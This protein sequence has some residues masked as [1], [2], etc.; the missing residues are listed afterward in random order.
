MC[1]AANDWVLPMSDIIE[2]EAAERR[3]GALSP[4]G[5]WRSR[6]MSKSLR[7]CIGT[8]GPG[9]E[10]R[11]VRAYVAIAVAL[12]MAFAEPTGAFAAA[13]R[14]DIVDG[15]SAASRKIDLEALPDVSM[16]AGVLV[17]GDGR[18]LWGR[19]PDARRSMASIT[20][21][22]TAVI[23]LEHSSPS[24][25][26]K[27]PAEAITVGQSS[28]GLA[29]GEKLTMRELLEALL[30]K[31]GNDAGIA[32]AIHV[33]GSE[34]RFVE[35]MNAKARGLGLSDT[36][37]ANSHGLDADGHYTTADDLAVLARYAM[38]NS[39][40]RDIVKRS[41]VTIGK[42]NRRTTLHTTDQLLGVYN[43]AVG[44]KTGFTSDAGYCVISAAQR[45]GVTLYAVVLGTES[46]RKRFTD[47]K[48]LLDWGFAHY[49]PMPL[50]E[51]G[52][53]IG[54][55]PVSSYLDRSVP[56]AVERSTAIA[57]LDLNGPIRRT[58]TVSAAPAPIEKG[59]RLGVATFRQGSRV[60]ATVPLAATQSLGRPNPFEAAWIATVRVW[61]RIFD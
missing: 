17:E 8:S 52:T 10:H 45:D 49:R 36:H 35:M 16:K 15:I 33:A 57:V 34:E 5:R 30:V 43:G 47:A 42:G 54:E 55:A 56:L 39:V 23:A 13:Q 2:P 51:K 6:A 44:V 25:E 11:R 41:T 28:A 1:S 21:V 61:K 4:C 60:V 24:D 12:L 40:F 46:D 38:T 22:M 53:V 50:V 19:A 59:Q 9:D 58:V 20:K 18:V 48:A 27:V 32:I 3:M 14:S 7:P 37:F 26:V 29:A 31:S